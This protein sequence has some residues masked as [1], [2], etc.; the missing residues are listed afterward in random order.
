[1]LKRIIIPSVIILLSYGFWISSEFKEIAAGV[2]IF[3]F[4]M[5]SLEEG[6]KAFSGGLLEKALKASTNNIFK[7][8]GFG[9]V[10]TTIMQSSSLVSVLTISFLGAG[11][12]EL[13]Q[14][15]GII[16][17]ANIGTTSGAWLMAGF[18]LKV[19]ISS[20]AM[21]MLVFGI[22]FIFQQ[23]KS[24]KGLGYILTGL[25]FLFFGIHHMKEGFETLKNIVDLSSFHID[26]F[27][28]VVVFVGI[29]I[30]ST[31]IMQS[32][33]AT[34]VLII[35]ALSVGE[36]SYQNALAL[37]IGANIG[38]TITA[39]IGSLSSNIDGKRLAGAHFIFNFIT[40]IIAIIILNPMMYTVDI[41]S[42]FL[43]ISLD[44][45]TLKLAVFDTLFKTMG[46]LIFFPF[47][48]MLTNILT[49]IMKDKKQINTNKNLEEILY[50]NE[51]VLELPSTAIA[52]ITNE[53]KHLYT[54]AFKIIANGLIL[55][56]RN[57]LS[58]MELDEVISDE[59][60]KEEVDV[61]RE[62][63]LRVK[64]ISG[65][66]LDFS[67]K[68]QLNMEQENIK[69]IY[70]LKLANR[71]IVSAIKSTQQ[72]CKNMKIYTKSQNHYIKNEYNLIRK[73]MIVLLRTIDMLSK[74]K[75]LQTS[76]KLIKNAKVQA[77]KND[78]FANGVLDNLIRESLIPNDIAI[79][80]M[81]DSSHAYDICQ[82]LINSA[83]ILFVNPIHIYEE[84]LDMLEI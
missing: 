40:G 64:D 49:R 36:V 8:I 74:E 59:Y 22:F 79:S 34:I 58:N 41:I 23:N 53:I 26:G 82:H 78:L 70:K 46:V 19:N 31:I 55:K 15:I 32:S 29:G 37:T 67:T 2:A 48:N 28:G 56:Q 60:I 45:F 52:S 72:L 27:K 12:I 61:N 1:M 65:A 3:L 51:A 63:L 20:Y 47:I 83:Q 18:G 38:T 69:E 43:G 39:I 62:Y 25:G 13:V 11:L 6:F 44:D 5:L 35:A 7:S 42:S 71:E 80:L 77:E 84:A 75:D 17:G 14:G 76:F 21:P 9:C 16:L 68:A 57:I 10:I 24:L 50:L 73:N 30:V 4:G 33:H 54:I 66:I 81:N